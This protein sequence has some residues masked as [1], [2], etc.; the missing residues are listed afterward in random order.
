MKS[1]IGIVCSLTVTRKFTARPSL[2]ALYCQSQRSARINRL[3]QDQMGNCFLHPEQNSYCVLKSLPS[4]LHSLW[5]SALLG[6]VLRRYHDGMS[7]YVLSR[8][9]RKLAYHFR[10][11][12][13]Q[14]DC[15]FFA[16]LKRF[17]QDHHTMCSLVELLDLQYSS[18]C[19]TPL[20]F[21]TAVPTQWS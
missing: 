18:T 14:F 19:S 2:L 1:V 6:F 3:E 12:F 7:T 4:L 15:H 5:L 21:K 11:P 8:S 16:R 10:T 13:D 9:E 17:C 20:A